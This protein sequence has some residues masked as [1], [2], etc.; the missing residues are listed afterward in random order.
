[1]NN[2]CALI[3]RGFS[4]CDGVKDTRGNVLSYTMDDYKENITHCL[5]E[6]LRKQYSVVDV[7]IFANN[8]VSQEEKDFFKPVYVHE[9]DGLD[10][11][12]LHKLYDMC[13]FTPKLYSQYVIH[14]FDVLYKYQLH[15]SHP[16]AMIVSPYRQNKNPK[17]V[18]W[19]IKHPLWNDV[20]FEIPSSCIDTFIELLHEQIKRNPMYHLM[21]N[22]VYQ[23]CLER[24]VP[25]HFLH[26]GMFNIEQ[27]PF[28]S[29]L[30]SSE[31]M[32]VCIAYKGLS[33]LESFRNHHGV[34]TFS[35][36]DVLDNHFKMIIEPLRARGHRVVFAISTN[37]SP[38]VEKIV[39]RLGGC[40]YV[41][42]DGTNQMD[43]A[44]CIMEHV[45]QDVTH[46]IMT[47]CDV[48]FKS[49]ITEIPIQWNKMN[50]SWIN[51]DRSYPRNGDVIYVF[52]NKLFSHVSS[53]YK[54]L[55]AYFTS[56]REIPHGHGFYKR[57]FKHMNVACMVSDFYN[58]NTDVT[59][60]PL[61]ELARSF[62]KKVPLH[63]K[64]QHAIHHMNTHH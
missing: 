45:P 6:P 63:P 4:H 17:N 2:A 61:F 50:F 62:D 12:Q 53:A 23:I 18:Q 25:V 59:Q 32:N 27:N 48:R 64:V 21:L 35:M 31:K 34:C 60:N 5:L 47:R 19:G 43:R 3:L 44:H 1:M 20:Y 8:V 26:Q 9:Y 55:H 14:R 56:R 15:F 41:S 39:Q 40:V 36:L 7:Y 49:K 51:F 52:P 30:R 24:G 42:T 13:T 22:G 11:T 58:S 57:F 33:Y 54:Q 38:I 28:F 46:V 16:K 37:A 10:S 29:F